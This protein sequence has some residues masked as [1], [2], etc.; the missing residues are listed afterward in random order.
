MK[1]G[2]ADSISAMFLVKLRQ[3][4]LFNRIEN[5]PRQMVFQPPG[6]KL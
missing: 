5:K 6:R 3:V 2:I 1:G 4:D